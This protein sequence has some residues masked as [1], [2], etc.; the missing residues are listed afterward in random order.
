MKKARGKKNTCKSLSLL[1]A[2]LY[3]LK[4]VLA[5]CGAFTLAGSIEKS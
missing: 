5:T 2:Q 3:T 4:G 1:R